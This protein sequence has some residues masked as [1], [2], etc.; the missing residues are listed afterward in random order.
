MCSAC[1]VLR[2]GPE[3]I[4]EVGDPA[5]TAGGAALNPLAERQRRIA[6]VNRLL[7]G[8]GVRLSEQGK[9]FIVRSATGRTELVDDLGH[10][11]PAADLLVGAKMDPL[12]D[13]FLEALRGEKD[14]PA[15]S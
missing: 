9:K 7:T 15:I 1:G 6:L 4:D 11:W 5:D 2:A 3:W 10:I 12:G 8:S 14:D 13:E